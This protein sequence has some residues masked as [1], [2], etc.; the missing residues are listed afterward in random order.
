M[1]AAGNSKGL[2]KKQDKD[3]E[4]KKDG[5]KDGDVAS[6]KNDGEKPKKTVKF[7]IDAVD[8]EAE[9]Q[10]NAQTLID[11]DEEAKNKEKAEEAKV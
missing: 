5:S 2:L 10:P 11:I 8:E 9:K 3:G 4:E 6:P 7:Q 1:K